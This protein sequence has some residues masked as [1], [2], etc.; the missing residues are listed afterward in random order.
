[1][2]MYGDDGYHSQM[3]DIYDEMERFLE[4]HPVSELLKIVSDVVESKE[5][6]NKN[7]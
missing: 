7:E 2:S 3:N 4:E 6:E 1:M 5:Y